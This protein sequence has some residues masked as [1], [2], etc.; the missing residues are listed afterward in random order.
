MTIG[1]RTFLGAL[2]LCA[3]SA[4]CAQLYA[5]AGIGLSSIEGA[6]ATT[7][8]A[9]FSIGAGYQLGDRFSVEAAFSD[10]GSGSV[11]ASQKGGA[12]T[13]RELD[14][15]SGASLAALLHFP[16]GTFTASLK[17]GIQ[18]LHGEASALFGVGIQWR[19]TSAFGVRA[20][21]E[22]VDGQRDVD[23]ITA[24]TASIIHRF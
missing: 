22:Y 15:G 20:M 10:Y 6:G 14:A 11:H 18:S 21:L 5:I 2:L 17:A 3:S 9:T 1:I 8:D 23:G 19:A 24:I 12:S 16:A 7:S 4:V 13:T